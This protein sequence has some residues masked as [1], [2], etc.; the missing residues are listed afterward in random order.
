MSRNNF[1]R[2]LIKTAKKKDPGTLPGGEKA[3]F[4]V[5]YPDPIYKKT[6]MTVPFGITARFL[7]ITIPSCTT[8]GP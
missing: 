7:T 5:K 3:P 8:Y 1:I 2:Y 4:A 6:Y